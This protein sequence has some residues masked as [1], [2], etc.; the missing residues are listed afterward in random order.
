MDRQIGTGVTGQFAV[1]FPIHFPYHSPYYGLT[2]DQAV[3]SLIII[4][5]LNQINIFHI[6]D[7]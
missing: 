5:K 7:K 1:R 2:L 3:Q 4:T 6:L